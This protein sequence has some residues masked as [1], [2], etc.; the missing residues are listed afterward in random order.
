MRSIVCTHRARLSAASRPRRVIARL[1]VRAVMDK[2]SESAIGR[3][4]FAQAHA[5]RFGHRE[6]CTDHLLLACCNPE[7]VQD[8]FSD[9]DY[10]VVESTFASLR[11]LQDN[12]KPIEDTDPNVYFSD[13]VKTV[14]KKG[15][16][17]AKQKGISIVSSDHLVAAMLSFENR[18]V[19]LLKAIDFPVEER[20][21]QM[22]ATKAAAYSMAAATGHVV[23]SSHKPPSGTVDQLCTDLTELA[24]Q[25]KLG[26]A[27]GRDRE[28]DRVVQILLRRTK[29][30]PLLVG[31]PGVG[32]TAIVEGLAVAS[33]LYPH[34]VP[35]DL[36]DKRIVALDVGAMMA[37]TKERGELEKRITQLVAELKDS[38][39]IVLFVDEIHVLFNASSN[40][41]GTSRAD[42]DEGMTVGNILKPALA[43]GDISCIGATTWDE[44]AKYF[45]RDPALSRRFQPVHVEGTSAAAT[46]Q[47]L[48]ELKARLESH[49]RVEYT[50]EA[51]LQA[52]KL[53]E[54]YIHYRNQPDKSIDAMDEAGS[55]VRMRAT[56][57]EAIAQVEKKHI[58][59]IVRDWSGVAFVDVEEDDLTASAERIRIDGLGAEIVG[60]EAAVAVVKSALMRATTGLRDPKRPV[61]TLFFAG[62]TGVGK[63]ELAK[64]LAACWFGD[65]NALVRV[66]M[67]EFMEAIDAS[68]IVGAPPGYVGYDEDRTLTE[69]LR[70]RPQCVLLLDEIEK[71]HRDV[72]NL[73]LQA[74]DDGRL[75]DGRGKTVVLK[76]VLIVLTSNLGSERPRDEDYVLEAIRK[77]FS[78]EFVNRLDEIVIFDPLG[79]GAIKAIY[80]GLRDRVLA[81]FS[82]AVAERHAC[83]GVAIAV[84]DALERKILEEGF[85]DAYGARPMRRAVTR[86]VED[87]LAELYLA[88]FQDPE[89]RSLNPGDTI[90]LDYA[91]GGAS[92]EIRRS[93]CEHDVGGG[94]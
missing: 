24:R 62:P 17:L 48:M 59:E 14:F 32:K 4:V 57:A 84:S 53:T 81:R 8:V 36:R 22:F 43:R 1:T 82:R 10:R 47:I 11:N 26:L 9:V 49:H 88:C 44:Y 70:R 15:I 66:D 37:G 55:L 65:P 46:L 19:V 58:E 50:P 60:Q 94:R 20:L 18:A 31:P 74:M 35:E 78:P 34:T 54:R 33:A 76:D 29:S 91:N 42:G 39:D 2:F 40:S 79:V 38:R 87:P 25:G 89:S 72:T 6:I 67:S 16:D 90:V 52:V 69:R 21:G 28:I 61:A 51:V 83:T 68:K 5:R 85:D 12:V 30:N 7:N 77:R 86:F 92:Y 45:Q 63:T 56:D 41:A 27:V 3:L 71:A 13:D 23:E 64:S 93:L 73:L 75:T 80:E